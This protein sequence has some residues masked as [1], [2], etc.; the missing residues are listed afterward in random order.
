MT[1]T[2]THMT[3]HAHISPMIPRLSPRV[4]TFRKIIQKRAHRAC[5]FCVIRN[6][7]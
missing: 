3:Q 4:P 7:R 1:H 2:M 6:R 5:L